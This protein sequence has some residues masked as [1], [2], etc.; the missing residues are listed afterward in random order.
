MISRS[1]GKFKFVFSLTLIMILAMTIFATACGSDEKKGPIIMIEQ[2][3][4]G[5]LVTTSVATILLREEMGYAVEQK[6]APADSAAMFA[7]LES[8]EF[9]FACCN[10]PSFSAGFIE[11]F[12]DG[13][14]SVE[15]VG[16]TGIVGTS[17]WYIPRY[18][19]EGDSERGI[20]AVAPNL[21]TYK[22]L[23]QYKDLFA[24]ADTGDKGRFIDHTPAWDY[25]NEE[26]LEALGVD[27]QV[28]YMGSETAAFAELDAAH[29]RGDP[30]LI[31]IWTPHWS[32]PKYDLVEVE[33]PAHGDGCYEA[34]MDVS[35]ARFDCGF[36]LDD[37][38]KLAWPGLKD[39]FPKAYEFLQNFAISND[40]QNGMVLAKVEGG[41]T[42]EEVAREWIDANEDTWKEWIP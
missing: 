17:N 2:D 18:V 35:A 19:V 6:F 39:E 9:H 28:T 15:R 29:L 13:K 3:W 12:V 32:I 33:I 14:G 23:N 27:F 34:G 16:S 8:G 37:V 36:T 5:Q 7:G 10:W 22:E 42:D 11:E 4:D 40:D 1:L 30:V 38:R 21:K 20:D 41:K 31:V 26:R 25:R 24:T